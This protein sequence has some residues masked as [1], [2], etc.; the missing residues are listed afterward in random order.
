MAQLWAAA[1]AEYYGI[2]SIQSF[3]GGTEATAFNK[4]AIDAMERAGFQI[5]MTHKGNNPIYEAMYSKN[6]ETHKMWS[7]KF[8]D[9][10][11]PSE[12]FAAVMV[13]SDADQNCPFVPGATRISMPFDDPKAFDGTNIE[14]AKYD[15][16]C[17]QI[18][19]EILYVMHQVKI[20]K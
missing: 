13:C 4:N 7:K 20:T 5:T 1:A 11:N 12:N 16:R 10:L 2:K 3:S 8:D 18:A 15:E 19:I 17:N 9:S 6:S 14:S